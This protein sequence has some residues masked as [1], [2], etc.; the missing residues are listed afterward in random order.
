MIKISTLASD[1]DNLRDIRKKLLCEQARINDQL[2]VAET[3]RKRKVQDL[4]DLVG[5]LVREFEQ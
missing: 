4:R 2:I 3:E 5:L 1:L